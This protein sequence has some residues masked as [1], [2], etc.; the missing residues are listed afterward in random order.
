MIELIL[1]VLKEIKID[2]YIINESK[3]ES[4]ELYLIKKD[5]D[6]NR[7]KHITDYTVTVFKD[8]G[9][10]LKG[11]S[12]V[13]IYPSMDEEEIKEVLSDA[14]Y[15]AGYVKNKFY[16]LPEGYNG[17]KV[18][19][20]SSISQN[21]LEETAYKVRDALYKYD[22]FEKGWINSSEIF[23]SKTDR[24]IVTSN[25]VDA[26]YEKYSI[27]GEFVTQWVENSDVEIFNMFSYDD[28]NE[29]ELALKGKE[30]IMN[31]DYRDKSTDAPLTGKYDVILSESSVHEFFKYY[32]SNSRSEMIYQKYSKFKKGDSV[33]GD[34]AVKGD[35]LNIEL[36][37]SVPFS[38]EGIVLNNISLIDD[39]VLKNIYGPYN[40]SQYLGLKP[41]GD[42]DGAV[43]K[44]GSVSGQ[45]MFQDGN[46]KILRFSDFQM[47][48]ITG[49]CF[50]EIRLAL[51][52]QG[53]KIIPLTGGSITVNVKDVEND[54]LLS[55][56]T[57]N[58]MGSVIP[59]Y[60]KFKN[61]EVA[62]K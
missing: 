48:E 47:D 5:I 42:F 10:D 61:V 43:I 35:K 6:M 11:N 60:I 45:E 62:G 34:K 23:V 24:R 21:T 25:N 41:V 44:G 52:K 27:E 39:G 8:N 30:A 58:D 20:N 55:K 32:L 17:D 3:K 50:G 46:L 18:Y 40:F 37:S 31:A 28:L 51:L 2:E 12:K 26:S 13:K 22:N 14:Y 15:A 56:E 33:Q 29:E 9:N 59:K 57:V 53:D 1:K 19:D 54:M 38:S 36:K 4:V 16:T 49:D 7:K